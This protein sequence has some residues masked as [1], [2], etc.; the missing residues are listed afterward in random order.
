MG[1]AAFRTLPIGEGGCR[2][3]VPI[4]V[5]RT[6]QHSH[7]VLSWVGSCS[8]LDRED[9]CAGTSDCSTTVPG[10][11]QHSDKQRAV[12][13]MGLQAAALRVEEIFTA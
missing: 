1:C 10:R 12:P 3:T 11:S 4:A 2:F 6:L 5:R 13:A 9:A 7:S 8:D